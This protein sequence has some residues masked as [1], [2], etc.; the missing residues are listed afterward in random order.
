MGNA[1]F[2]SST[3]LFPYSHFNA[4]IPE[5]LFELLSLLAWVGT[6]GKLGQWIY[7]GSIGFGFWGV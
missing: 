4:N 3:V 1:E 7:Y 5:T 6:L 2:I